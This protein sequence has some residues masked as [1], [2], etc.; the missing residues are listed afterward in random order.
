MKSI[1]G[2]TLVEIIVALAIF[3]V[4]VGGS[5]SLIMSGSDVFRKN[6]DMS[7]AARMSQYTI[8]WLEDELIF[9]T[10][11]QVENNVN[12][13]PASGVRAIKIGENGSQEGHLLRYTEGA[14]QE[15]FTSGFYENF[16]ISIETDLDGTDRLSLNVEVRNR[17]DKSIHRVNKSLSFPNDIDLSVEGNQLIENPVI[18]YANNATIPPNEQ[19]EFENTPNQAAIG[20]NTNFVFDSWP[21]INSY[22]IENKNPSEPGANIPDNSIHYELEDYEVRPGEVLEAGYYLTRRNQYVVNPPPRTKEEIYEYLYGEVHK[23]KEKTSQIAQGVY[24]TYPDYKKQPYGIKIN[25]DVDP[26]ELPEPSVNTQ[27]G[28]LRKVGT[29]ENM[30]L[31][32]FFPQVTRSWHDFEEPAPSDVW[33]PIPYYSLEQ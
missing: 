27:P 17:N 32:V 8:D 29:G 3:A 16:I 15:V 24:V 28:D 18:F 12:Q 20:N 19:E 31:Y 21:G 30:R 33:R 7:H 2:F 26:E 10:S 1:K 6:A 25:L 5:A 22:V 13:A 14:W 9:A 11:M 23:N 4:I